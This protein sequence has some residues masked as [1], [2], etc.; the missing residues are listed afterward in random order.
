M[1]IKFD[2]LLNEMGNVLQ[3][4]RVELKHVCIIRLKSSV[5]VYI[6]ATVFADVLEE[7]III[8]FV[9]IMDPFQTSSLA[10]V[11]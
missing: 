9:I 7:Y 5:S 8:I 6:L 4:G 10:F 3:K 2:K 11:F 1:S